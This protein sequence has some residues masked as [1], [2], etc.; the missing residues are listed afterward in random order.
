M[1]A[2]YELLNFWRS[3]IHLRNSEE[4]ADAVGKFVPKA[5]DG[6][7]SITL[8]ALEE[9]PGNPRMLRVCGGAR[10]GERVSANSS[11][12]GQAL[13]VG[14]VLNIPPTGADGTG[15]LLLP[16]YAESQKDQ[17]A[18]L[19]TVVAGGAPATPATATAAVS[20]VRYSGEHA[21]L[22]EKLAAVRST[23]SASCSSSSL[24]ARAS[25]SGGASGGKEPIRPIG[26][27]ALTRQGTGPTL[28]VRRERRTSAT[29]E[30][31]SHSLSPAGSP[32]PTAGVLNGERPR[33]SSDAHGPDRMRRSSNSG[34][35]LTPPLKQKDFGL[36][37]RRSSSSSYDHF[38][39]N[40]LDDIPGLARAHSPLES[41]LSQP[42]SYAAHAGAPPP[43]VPQSSVARER[44]SS[45]RSIFNFFNGHGSGG[46]GNGPEAT[47]SSSPPRRR[48]R[49]SGED[50]DASMQGDM[51]ESKSGILN[52]HRRHSEPNVAKEM[53]APDAEELSNLLKGLERRGTEELPLDV[54]SSRKKVDKG[55]RKSIETRG[56]QRRDSNHRLASELEL[57][58]VAEQKLMRL[59]AVYVGVALNRCAE[60]RIL[61]PSDPIS[62]L[63]VA[64]LHPSPASLSY[65]HSQNLPESCI[66]ELSSARQS[67]T[68]STRQIRWSQ[69]CSLSTLR[70][71]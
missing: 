49:W 19:V 25:S 28:P 50:M 1:L 42:M 10:V 7:E 5:L 21:S 59:I 24:S 3:L 38:T 12:L 53:V 62:L 29:S 16:I 47:P 30:N 56:R 52:R 55:A 67:T 61:D 37:E 34:G 17:T 60:R 44:R 15:M 11:I 26:L 39:R 71:S 48:R 45:E 69:R 43:E 54:S 18:D 9:T 66:A 64:I 23:S 31:I 58:T 2:Q 65:S 68:S 63:S 33:R 57:F 32:R 8:Y 40:S 36:R 41:S 22:D 27:L 35:N 13:A 70:G 4:V 14:E 46:D 20:S 51:G 6:L